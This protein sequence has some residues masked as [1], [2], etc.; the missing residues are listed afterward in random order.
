MI[1]TFVLNVQVCNS[2]RNQWEFPM[3]VGKNSKEIEIESVKT[4]R[5][6]YSECHESKKKH[7]TLFGASILLTYNL[8]SFNH[9]PDVPLLLVISHP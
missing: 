9:L 2:A 7:L 6:S 1:D 3:P 8:E 4:Q 5:S